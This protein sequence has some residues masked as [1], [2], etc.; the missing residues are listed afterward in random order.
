M[1]KYEIEWDK[2]PDVINKD[3]FYR[4]CHISKSTAL[5]QLRSGKVSCEWSGKKTRCYKIK[6]EYV[7]AYLEKRAVFPELYSAPRG[8]YGSHYVAKLS[9]NYP[10]KFSAKCTTTTPDF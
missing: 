9:K 5:H 7:K 4:F 6:K 10:K 3:Q 8:W 1:Q 2:I